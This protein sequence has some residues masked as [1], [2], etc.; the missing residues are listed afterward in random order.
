MK[1]KD[2]AESPMQERLNQACSIAELENIKSTKKK[3][4]NKKRMG[5]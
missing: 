3:E 2:H 4:N 5:E 1:E